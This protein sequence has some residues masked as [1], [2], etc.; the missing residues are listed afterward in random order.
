MHDY[1]TIR[2]TICTTDF[3]HKNC[4]HT[5]PAVLKIKKH[6]HKK[7][8]STSIVVLQM[9][10]CIHPYYSKQHYTGWTDGHMY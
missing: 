6:T 8:T 4:T 7:K 3:I 1:E 9:L 10:N 5:N 2:A